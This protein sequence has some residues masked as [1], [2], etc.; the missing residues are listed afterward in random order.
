MDQFANEGWIKKGFRMIGKL[1][2][3]LIFLGI[4]FLFFRPFIYKKMGWELPK[5]NIQSHQHQNNG[6]GSN[7]HQYPPPP[8]F[9]K[10]LSPEDIERLEEEEL[11]QKN[12]N[13]DEYVYQEKPEDYEKNIF[14]YDDDDTKAEF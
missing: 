13:Y 2:I 14:D 5:P 4:V 11:R 6:A 3:G 9:G 1:I 7:N 12:Q 8:P 10:R